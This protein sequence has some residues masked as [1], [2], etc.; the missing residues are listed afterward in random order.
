[1]L[2][3]SG[4]LRLKHLVALFLNFFVVGQFY[5]AL[6]PYRSPHLGQSSIDLY[7]EAYG[8]IPYPN[9][10]WWVMDSFSLASNLT[11]VKS[12]VFPLWLWCS[13]AQEKRA[14]LFLGL[15][16]IQCTAH[17]QCCFPGRSVFGTEI[18]CRCPATWDWWS[19]FPV[20]KL[21]WEKI[22]R[23]LTGSPRIQLRGEH[24]VLWC[25]SVIFCT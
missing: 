16:C 13:K 11:S 17:I 9:K 19:L 2:P 1:M 7:R 15:M 25:K 3:S 10:E 14:L 18:L 23:E 6:E 8:S 22:H 21:C 5:A 12:K 24:H 4:R 20:I